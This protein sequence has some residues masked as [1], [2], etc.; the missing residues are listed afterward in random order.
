MRRRLVTALCSSWASAGHAAGAGVVFSLGLALQVAILGSVT[1]SAQSR[2]DVRPPTSGLP[3]WPVSNSLTVDVASRANVAVGGGYSTTWRIGAG[4]VITNSLTIGGQ[5]EPAGSGVI[6]N[7]IATLVEPFFDDNSFVLTLPDLFPGIPLVISNTVMAI[8]PGVHHQR[9]TFT[10]DGFRSLV[11][12]DTVVAQPAPLAFEVFRRH[13]ALSF[14]NYPITYSW[15]VFA[16][17]GPMTITTVVGELDGSAIFRSVLANQ[18]RCESRGLTSFACT[19]DRLS[20]LPLIITYTAE[21]LEEGRNNHRLRLSGGRG[22]SL[23]VTSS[24]LALQSLEPV[25]LTVQI[26]IKPGGTRNPINPQSRGNIPVAI[27]STASFDAPGEIDQTTL[28]FG[29][30]GDEQSLKFCQLEDLNQDGL[31]DLACHFDTGAAGF[32]QGDVA[33]I[34]TGETFTGA[35][36]RGTDSVA[37]VPNR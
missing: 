11:I 15:Q 20:D 22:D 5:I 4:R 2:D 10:P 16:P 6:T 14:T 29:R 8:E 23:V 27:L 25:A 12:S 35:S 3:L 21:A 7:V 9:L 37:I 31:F 19:V 26:D 24:N 28:R 32:R 36:I 33:G 13:P 34:L 17:S 18:G 1:P 30:I